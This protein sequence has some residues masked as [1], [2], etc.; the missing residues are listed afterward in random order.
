MTDTVTADLKEE[1]MTHSSQEERTQPATEG[2]T[3]ER[4]GGSGGRSGQEP[5]RGQS[6]YCGFVGRK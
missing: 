6:L 1:F 3:E 5:P 4:R 2:H